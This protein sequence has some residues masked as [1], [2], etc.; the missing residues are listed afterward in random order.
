MSSAASP[1][2]RDAAEYLARRRSQLRGGGGSGGGG[3]GVDALRADV[4]AHVAELRAE[5]VE[6]INRDY[7]DFVNVSTS[8]AGVDA[9]LRDIRAPLAD[10]RGNVD[11]REGTP[12]RVR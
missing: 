12:E 9:Q 1:L 10:I 8:L 2:E 5:L 7:A 4:A 6:L 11:V 3:V